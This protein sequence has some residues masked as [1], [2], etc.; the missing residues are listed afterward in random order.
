MA[1]RKPTDAQLSL[2]TRIDNGAGSY[3]VGDDRLH[4]RAV[5]QL[6]NRG[7]VIVNKRFAKTTQDGLDV[8]KANLR[9]TS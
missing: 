6:V 3:Y 9:G 5:E 7:W 2:L 8:L 4:I 1:G